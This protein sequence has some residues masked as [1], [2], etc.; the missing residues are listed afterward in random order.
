MAADDKGM[1][2]ILDRGGNTVRG[3]GRSV[4]GCVAET[5]NNSKTMR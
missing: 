4:T 5:K 1:W 3:A 2:Y